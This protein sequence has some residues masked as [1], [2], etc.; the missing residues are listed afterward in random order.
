[1]YQ[2]F[3]PRSFGYLGFSSYI[4]RKCIQTSSNDTIKIE[5]GQRLE[6]AIKY[7]SDLVRKHDPENYLVSMF[8]PKHLRKI[9]YAIRAFN[10]ELIMVRDS[11]SSPQIGKIRMQFWR[12][13]IDNVFKGKPPQQP[14]AQVLF[15]ALE[16]CRLSPLFFKRVIDERE[17]I[18]DDL[19]YFATKDLE[20]YGENTASC[21]LYLHLESLNVKDMQADHVASHIGKAIG[22]VTILRAFPYL[23]SKRRMLLSTEILAKHNISQEE[24]FRS[25]SVKGL[26]DA[27][28]EVAT[29]AHDHL[30]TARSF[31]PDIPGQALPALL[32]AVPCDL[33]LK[34]LEKYNFNVFEPKVNRKDW[35]LPIQL[36]H[37]YRKRSF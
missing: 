11:V 12:D 17:A 36:W 1:M 4:S 5:N 9:Y 21:L 23:A 3:F 26:D 15:N 10:L 7:C 13:T 8:Y 32:S 37:R 31:L 28:F 34:R 18:L 6:A 19:P 27:V 33:Y 29:L 20:S 30:L 16:T 24:I 22:I 35:R 14:I 25:G 2:V